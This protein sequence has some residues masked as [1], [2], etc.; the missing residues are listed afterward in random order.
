[1]SIQSYLNTHPKISPEHVY[2]HS[3]AHVIG[4]VSIGS[5]S[6]IWC[7]AVIR[8]DV[9][10]IYI[11][12]YTNIQDLSMV[13]VSHKQTNK[14]NGSSTYIGDYVT[15]GHGVI[16]HG[17][18]IGNECLIGMGSMIM[19]DAIIEPYVMVGAGSLISPNKT[20]KSYT[21]YLGRPAIAVREL[22]ETEISY[23]KYSAMHYCQVKNNYLSP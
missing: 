14:I 23:L 6:S 3:S 13:H 22:T 16:L 15:V 18:H 12:A 7:N 10:S 1:M 8:G 11:G 4:D 20:L 19:D 5:H 2:I 21:L 9:N 17:C